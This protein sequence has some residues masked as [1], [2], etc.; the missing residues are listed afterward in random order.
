MSLGAGHVWRTVTFADALSS[1]HPL[2]KNAL[3]SIVCAHCG[4]SR[5]A[6]TARVRRWY[7]GARRGKNYSRGSFRF[8]GGRPLGTCPEVA[9]RRAAGEAEIRATLDAFE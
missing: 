7:Q 5:G 4:A 6:Q 8:H 3:W 9:R 1:G 2:D